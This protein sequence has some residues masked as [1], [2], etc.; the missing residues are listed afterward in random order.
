MTCVFSCS[1]KGKLLA[2]QV[3]HNVPARSNVY[4]ALNRSRQLGDLCHL[5]NAQADLNVLVNVLK[6]Q[7]DI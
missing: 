4:L 3:Y 7:N 2:I 5:Q 6:L 1:L